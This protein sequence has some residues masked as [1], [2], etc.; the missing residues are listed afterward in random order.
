[1]RR[2][3][4]LAVCAAIA[5][6][7]MIVIFGFSSQ[8]CIDTNNVSHK[9]TSKIAEKAFSG[10]SQL[11]PDTQSIV[12]EQLNHFIRKLAH[13]SLFFI[14]GFMTYSAVFI[15]TCRYKK[16]FVSA[17]LVSL[18]YGSLDELH[19]MFV[20]GR[21]PLVKDVIID[22]FGGI[23][24]AVLCLIL[25]SAAFTIKKRREAYHRKPP[26]STS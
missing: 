3:I 17:A 22:T 13:F 6:I 24:G 5:G 8:N 7:C 19:Q 16:S 10:Y 18:V 25:I 4:G 26:S 1:M 20:P 23:C 12:T 14:L 21:T 11:T 9:V 15:L 2:K